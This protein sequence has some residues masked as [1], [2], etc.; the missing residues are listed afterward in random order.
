MGNK[1][2]TILSKTNAGNSNAKQA[3]VLTKGTTACQRVN[4]RMVQSVLL[5]WLDANIDVENDADCRN[6]ITQLQPVVNNV[7]TFTNSDQCIEFI[8][9]IDTNNNKACMIISGSLGQQIVPRVHNM[10]QVDS[11]FIFCNS[12]K[13]HE[14]W[15]KDWAKIKGV[16]TEITPICKALKEATQQCEHNA[17]PISFMTTGIDDANQ[18]RLDQLDCSFMY[19]QILKDILLTISFEQKHM[20][21]Y[22]EHC[23]EQFADIKKELV[24]VK[25]LERNYHKYTPVWWYTCES[26]LYP[27]L[28]SALRLMDVDVMIKMGFFITDLHRQIQKLHTEQLDDYTAATTLTVYRGQGMSEKD[29]EQMTKTKG[30]LMAFNSFLS[31]SKVRQVS[32][33]FARRALSNPDLVGILFVMTIDPSHST[34]PFASINDVGFFKDREDEVLFS[35]HSV[36]RIRDIKSMGETSRL[37]QVNLTLTN[38]NDK[39]LCALTDR[40]A[41]EMEGST[42]WDR[43]GQLLLKMRQSEKAEQIYEILLKQATNEIEKAYSYFRLGWAKDDQGEYKEALTLYEKSLAIRE[44][45][46]HPNHPDLAKSYGNIGLVYYNMGEYLKALSYYEKA[47]AIRQQ[48]LPPTHPDLASSYNNI[49]L[50]YSSMGEYSKALSYYEKA[51]AIRQQSLLPNHPDLAWSYGSIGGVYSSMGEYLKA[52]SYY[53]KALAIRQQSLPPTHPD[54]AWSYGSIG[55]VYFSMGEYSKALSY[56]EKALAIRQQSLPPNHPV[57]AWSYGSIGLVYYNMGEY[58]KT[59]SYYE[60]ALAIREQSLPPNHPDLASSYNIIGVEYYNMGEYSKAFSYYEKALAIR[61]QSLPPTHP[62]LAKSY[63]NIGLVYSNMGEYS[64]ALSSHEKALAIKQQSLPPTHPDLAWS[65]DS[66]GSVYSSMGEYSEALTYYEKA[67]AILRQSLPPTHPDFAKSYNNIGL[68]YSSMG[69][70]SE[71]HSYYKRALEIAQ[72]SLP[73]NQPDLQMYSRNL[74]RVKNL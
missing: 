64:K 42:G 5:I 20:Q 41:E 62:D 67:L 37:Y 13:Y 58:S 11:I 39:D 12:K 10:S 27:M 56:Y 55:L 48:S 32:L 54:L 15:T 22:I 63:G 46:L 14:Q 1:I 50:V 38:D 45:S 31:T 60:K 3:P 16:F 61:Q 59:L 6:T 23:R 21:E 71:S 53:E 69:E 33:N 9:T 44:Q 57:L 18:K 73:P 36:F 26:F 40:I 28:N 19:T 72:Q 30:G 35:M 2:L 51:L 74:E 43:L 29:F 4:I 49:G 25:E 8:D 65:F 7:N 52:L 24:N 34:T 68:V 47:L 17:T 66:I 70:Y